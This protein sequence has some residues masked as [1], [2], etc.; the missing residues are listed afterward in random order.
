[1]KKILLIAI[2]VITM[3]TLAGC[4][5]KE[6]DA[7]TIANFINAYED[8]DIEI[9]EADKPMFTMIGA[10]DGVIF[11]IENEV[12]KIYEYES[13]K[14]LEKAR[15]KYNNIIDDWENNGKFLLETNS[16]DATKIFTSINKDGMTE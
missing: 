16:E 7:R 5:E 6:S 8:A 2:F 1:M 15:E 3:G 11:Y 9:D 13:E 12:V 10:K 14:D 4:G